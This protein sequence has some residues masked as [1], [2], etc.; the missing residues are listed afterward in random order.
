MKNLR[1][2]SVALAA[3][4][5]LSAALV[6][7]PAVASAFDASHPAVA[8]ALAHLAAASELASADDTFVFKD[9]VTDVDGSE[10]VR[11]DRQYKS[12]R[13]IGGDLVV[14]GTASGVARGFSHTLSR[15]PEL[16][17][18]PQLAA[19]A[20]AAQALSAF[21]HRQGKVAGHELV[22]YARGSHAPQLAWD[23]TV[24]GVQKDGTPSRA[25]LFISA[26]SK[27]LV[28]QWDEIET[29][30]HIGTGNTLYSGTVSLND[31]FNTTSSIYTLTDATRGNAYVT[32]MK[33]GSI[34]KG[35]KFTDTNATW[36]DGTEAS[37][38]SA[39]ADAAYGYQTTWDY[40][41]NVH[42][43]NGIANDGKGA[44]SKVHYKKNYDNAYWSDSCFCMTYGD[45]NVLNPLVS[46]DVAGHEM[47]HGVTSRTAGLIYSGESGGLNEGTS[48]I[49][50]TMVEFYANNAN[51]PGDYLIGEKLYNTG[52]ALRYMANPS[53]DGA[54]ADCWYAGVGNLDV[55]YSSGVA[56]HLYYLMA[57]GTTNGS[58]SKTCVSGNTRVASGTGTVVGLG[59]A[60]A[61]KV[62]YRALTVYMT[63]S[64]DFAAAR[65]ATL[66]AATDLYGAGSAEVA[67]VAAAW[68]AVGRN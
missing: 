31:S 33:N 30:K 57:E 8:R 4:A 46:L 51:D 49:F 38:E 12:L 19:E 66:S 52:K 27:Q 7:Q 9:L 1:I 53:Q 68:T 63:A 2:R 50:G 47:S 58:P 15:H 11:F 54:S 32:N 65:A 28:D 67:S 10:H 44:Y 37:A 14:H 61:E 21:P 23:V 3:A 55:H 56:N 34:G 36:G 25:H 13:V 24:E 6:A 26:R 45:G 64:T 17:V 40:Y 35:T 60:K 39:A 41:K 48:D 43:R 16:A 29:A 42:G 62:W 5:A 59:R 22:I 18:Q 20:A